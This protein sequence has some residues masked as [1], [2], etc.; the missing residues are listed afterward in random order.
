MVSVYSDDLSKSMHSN[1]LGQVVYGIFYGEGYVNFRLLGYEV[2]RIS[3]ATILEN[4]YQVYLPKSKFDL[5]EYVV[6]ANKWEQGKDEVP[7]K[8]S[9]ISAQQIAFNNPQTTGD[10][11]ANSGEVYVQKSQLGGGSPVIRGFEA[12]RILLLVDGV[13]MNSAIFRAGHLQIL[14]Q[15]II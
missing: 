7:M 10:I 15:W 6:S 4:E 1:H 9:L 5:G 12:S 2:T 13:R 14:S 3:M 11:L 8:M